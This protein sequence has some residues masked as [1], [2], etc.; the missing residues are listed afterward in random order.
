MCQFAD[1]LIRCFIPR[2]RLD[3][4]QRGQLARQDLGHGAGA[5]AGA[6]WQ[7][8]IAGARHALS[9]PVDAIT[10]GIG[11]PGPRSGRAQ[12]RSAAD[13]RPLRHPATAARDPTQ[14]PRRAL[15]VARGHTNQEIADRLS[16]SV[17]TVE[18][19]R[20]RAME[21]LGL[22]GRAALVRYALEKGWLGE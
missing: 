22:T 18:T 4:D 5:G 8:H 16:L 14:Q 19:Y 17:K 21:K 10:G 9:H 6:G 12:H 2:P 15:Q 7:H 3:A 11:Q 1:S 13:Q 20:G